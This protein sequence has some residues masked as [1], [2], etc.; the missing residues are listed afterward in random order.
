METLLTP[1]MLSR[2]QFAATAMFHIIWPVL[3]IGLSIFLLVMEILWLKTREDVY[4]R[5]FQFWSRLFLLNFTVGAVTGIPME[6]QFGTNWS[7]FS[8]AGGDVLGHLLGFEGAMAFML[9]AT[10]LSIMM[11]GW[12]RVS[13]GMHLL[14]TALVAFA[15]S[16]SAFWIMVAN[17][18]MHT[19]TGG[20]MKDGRF[21][22]TSHFQAIFNPDMPWGVSHMW[23]ACLEISIFVVG[24]LSAWYMLR[25]RH[26]SF[27]LHSFKVA[28]LAAIV[29]TPLQIWL[30]DGSGQSV[31]EY[32]PAKLAGIES[33]WHTN[34]PGEGAPWHILAWPDAAG[35]ENA[36]AISIPNGLS[37]VTTRTLT[38]PVKG[39]AD[40]P[41]GDRPPVV[42]P[43]YAFRIMIAIGFALFVLMLW[44]LWAWHKGRL[45]SDLVPGQRRLLQAW[46]IAIPLSYVAM[47]AGWVTREVG[48]QPWVLYNLVRTEESATS[49]AAGTVGS[50][51]LIFSIVYTL[52]FIL[53]LVFARRMVVRGPNIE[54]VRKQEYHPGIIS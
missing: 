29:I 45:T 3:T 19:P 33:H 20:F 34:P 32:Q 50:S 26:T 41:P 27:F 36:W 1:V 23:V 24:G 12:K 14:A 9:E 38:G 43:F 8:L 47:Q 10:F 48:R 51:L 31:F 16:L 22:I 7:G 18:W 15:G 11:F 52:L 39:L 53:F 17:S 5:H 13:P 40:F 44:T 54:K 46:V 21:V 35:Q 30:G 4:F 28:V 37:L 6:F 49:L 42:I 2:I 25:N